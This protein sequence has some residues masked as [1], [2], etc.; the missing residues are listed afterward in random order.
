MHHDHV[1]TAECD[2]RSFR[3]H[4]LDHHV[5]FGVDGKDPDIPATLEGY[6]VQGRFMKFLSL[7][8]LPLGYL[9]RPA[10]VNPKIPNLWEGVNAAVVI[11][12]NYFIYTYW[13][14]KAMI[15]LLLSCYFALSIH[16][17]AGHF[18]SEHYLIYPGVP[19]QETFSYYGMLNKLTYNFGYH[20]EHHDFPN[21]PG[22]RLPHV[23]K[24]GAEFYDLPTTPAWPQTMVDYVMTDSVTAFSRIKRVARNGGVPADNHTF[25]AKAATTTVFL[26]QDH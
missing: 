9:I 14:H 22:S 5:H 21:V 17:L 23:K 4:H 6:Y 11:T 7:V 15:Y 10:F 3:R 16:P 25:D 24:Q 13:G 1:N 8:L 18:I 19:Y 26:L 12:T 20:V 2:L